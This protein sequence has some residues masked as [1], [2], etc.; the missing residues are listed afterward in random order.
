MSQP[1]DEPSPGEPRAGPLDLE[2]V[3][4]LCALDRERSVYAAARACG[5][6]R[7]TAWRKLAELEA[8][9]GCRLV[10]RSPRHLRLTA[11]GAALV[12][13]GRVLLKDAETA[14]AEARS[15]AEPWNG[16]IKIGIPPGPSPEILLAGLEPFT[17]ADEGPSFHL[18]E[19]ASALHPLKDDFDLIVTLTP[20]QDGD[21]FVRLLDTVDWCCKASP[22]YLE[23]RPPVRTLADLHA[24]R[25]LSYHVPPRGPTRW[26]LREGGFV[27]VRPRLAITNAETIVRATHA[28]LGIGYVPWD[29]APRGGPLVD[30]LPDLVGEKLSIYLVAGQR[31]RDSARVRLVQQAFERL[32]EVYRFGG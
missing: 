29:L 1:R 20:P 14:Q 6:S 17:R 3:A 2:A 13:R 22:A 31:G 15:A 9:L 11:A 5:V 26:A 10:E 27:H 30:V 16:V 18:F 12:A 19:S 32:R 4:I 7:S 23:G 8:A 24:H 25:L 21:L 28:G